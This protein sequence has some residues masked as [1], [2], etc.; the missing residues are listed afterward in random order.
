MMTQI[1]M[2][3]SSSNAMPPFESRIPCHTQSAST[4]F[5]NLFLLSLPTLI[6]QFHVPS[7]LSS[8]FWAV[9]VFVP[10]WFI[11][12]QCVNNEC[13][14]SGRL[15]SSRL[16]LATHPLPL[17]LFSPLPLSLA[18]LKQAS[19]HLLHLWTVVSFSFVFCE[20]GCQKRTHTHTN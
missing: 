9:S 20:V 3:S 2:Q 18:I 14:L 11:S 7:I 12:L 8:F 15:F 17:Y 1:N 13:V 5:N 19:V 4:T 10:T 6:S 16:P